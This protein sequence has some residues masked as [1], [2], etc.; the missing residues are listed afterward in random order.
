MKLT[1]VW[2]IGKLHSCCRPLLVCLCNQALCS[3]T[4]NVCSGF[5]LWH[6]CCVPSRLL[7]LKLKVHSKWDILF[8][9]PCLPLIGIG[10]FPVWSQ[11]IASAHFQPQF[12]TRKSLSNTQTMPE[13]HEGW[14]SEK[15]DSDTTDN[16]SNGIVVQSYEGIWKIN[17]SLKLLYCL[18]MEGK[19]TG[20]SSIFSFVPAFQLWSGLNASICT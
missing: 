5:K 7:G 17:P 2:N 4:Y 11:A 14:E 20:T 13:Q 15:W 10:Q 1:G 3:M 6:R 19:I 8:S 18:I 12:R 9:S 16:W